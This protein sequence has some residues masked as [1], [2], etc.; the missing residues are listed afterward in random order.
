M[1]L[2]ERFESLYLPE[3]NSGCW[4]WTGSLNKAGYGEFSIGGSK[5]AAYR[6]SYYLYKGKIPP[7]MNVCHA[8]DTPSCVNP[9]HLWLGTHAENIA[10]AASK[11]RMHPGEK[12]GSA[13]LKEQEVL[14]IVAMYNT[15]NFTR[16]EL[17]KKFSVGHSIIGDIL[18][19]NKWSYLTG[20]GKS[21]QTTITNKTP[22]N[23]GPILIDEFSASITRQDE[24]WLWNAELLST[25]YGAMRLGSSVLLAHRISYEINNG[26]IVDG[27]FVCHSCDIKACVNPAHL[28]LGTQQEN[29]SDAANKGILPR[30]EESIKS[31]LTENKIVEMIGLYSTGQYSQEQVAAIFGV[32]HSVLSN[33]LHNR[34]WTHLNID[35]SYRKSNGSP[36]DKNPS[37]LH[38]EKLARGEN[39]PRTKITD[40]VVQ[41]I[42]ALYGQLNQSQLS[43]QFNISK[44]QIGRILR[45]ESRKIL[46]NK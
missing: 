8:C 23:Y 15:G 5:P 39:H 22:Q 38:P 32:Q 33:I 14:D 13:K 20:R 11:N 27:K 37:R 35:R 41:E 44:T 12:N 6:L 19:G 31:K 45:G 18:I 28:W 42:R 16:H 24:C 26:E 3:P 17:A 43:K 9:D 4:L 30:G 1:K 34:S 10:D 25:G 29:M 46:S 40:A 7:K 36:G 2:V 21:A